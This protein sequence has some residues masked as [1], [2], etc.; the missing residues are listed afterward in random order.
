MYG[1]PQTVSPDTRLTECKSGDDRSL[2]SLGSRE[3]Q[4]YVHPD[5]RS[6]RFGAIK[7]Q[8]RNVKQPIS[9]AEPPLN[10]KLR[11]GDVFFE[12]DDSPMTVTPEPVSPADPIAS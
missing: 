5:Y 7:N 11:Q 8:R 1:M 12:K 4:T 2:S 6:S 3:H 10:T 9:Y